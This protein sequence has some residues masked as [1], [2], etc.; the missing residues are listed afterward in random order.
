MEKRWV[1][2][3]EA[4]R[5]TEGNLTLMPPEV[6]PLHECAQRIAAEDVYAQIDS[7]SLTASLK[8]G[9]AV[10]ASDVASAGEKT[11]VI[12]PLAGVVA[13]GETT[14]L[15]LEKGQTI[16]ILTGAPLPSGAEAVVSQE[17]TREDDRQITFFA[18]AEAG[19]NVLKRGT[20]VRKGEQIVRKGEILTAGHAGLL[21]AAGLESILVHRLPRVAIA[22]TG[23]EIIAP[24]EPFRSGAIFAS[25]LVTLSAFLRHRKIEVVTKI[26]KDRPEQIREAVSSLLAESDVLLTIGGAWE[27]DKDYALRVLHD[28]GW[29]A[30]YHRVRIGPGKA[31]SFG[32][33][34]GKPVFC[35]PGGPPSNEMAFLQIAFP[36]ILAMSGDSSPA[37]AATQAVLTEEVR[38]QKD[39]TQFIYAELRE[40]NS[41]W[42]ATPLVSASRLKNMAGAKG[43]IK[44]PEGEQVLASGERI[45]VQLLV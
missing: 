31:V 4:L 30:Y 37:L 25:N 23:D 17:F 40:E 16:R 14:F 9:Y 10:C 20:D 28:L 2:L 3:E 5:L 44:I 34:Q 38:G 27:G 22:A 19:R 24:G 39:W 32:V 18:H 41:K 11:P 21:A 42:Y 26:I 13:A 12:L 7:P 36:A 1:G 45:T 15:A 6:L 33:L 8:D 35:L 29:E 43:L